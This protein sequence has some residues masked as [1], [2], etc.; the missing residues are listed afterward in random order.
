MGTVLFY[1]LTRS[2]AAETAA[3]LL[4]R[5]LAQGWRVMVRG[6]DRGR[7]E[8]LDE[9]LWLGRDEDFLPHGL[10]GGPQDADQP[11]LLGLGAPVNGARALM[12]ADGAR[13]TAEEARA[14]ERVWILFD[15]TDAAALEAARAQW[16][17]VTGW[18]VAAQY[19]SEEGGRWEKKAEKAAEAG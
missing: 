11:I 2:G 4:P 1:H 13:C 12:L 3:M 17:E 6:T 14:M 9:K 15:G 16:R 18:G 8:W 7:L 19:W 5:A 10:E